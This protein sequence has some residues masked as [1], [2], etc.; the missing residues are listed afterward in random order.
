[1][2]KAPIMQ[3]YYVFW[4]YTN[5]MLLAMHDQVSETYYIMLMLGHVMMPIATPMLSH[6]M[7][8]QIIL[9]IIYYIKS[10]G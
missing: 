7:L 10:A 1:M 4:L 9:Q 8:I 3:E 6:I 5:G 2:A